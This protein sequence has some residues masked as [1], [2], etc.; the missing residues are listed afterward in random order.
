MRAEGLRLVAGLGNPGARYEDT[1]HNIGFR[2]LDAWAGVDGWQCDDGAAWKWHGPPDG[3]V[4]CL[5]PQEFMN[6]SGPPVARFARRWGI[7]STRVLVLHDELD[8]PAARVKLKKRGGTAGHRGL[9][10]LVDSL[11]TS[12]F[13]RLRLGIGRPAPGQ[14]VVDFVLEAFSGAEQPVVS[15]LIANGVAGIELWLASGTDS[16][17]NQ[18][19]SGL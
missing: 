13:P 4:L 6:V 18:L 1:R 17:M 8:L 7:D 3:R 10:S 14:A 19:N 16:A 11:G 2:A 12:H 15:E 5:K 9:A